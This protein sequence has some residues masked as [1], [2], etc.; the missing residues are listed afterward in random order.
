M[1]ANRADGRRYLM[2]NM[3]WL[4][5]QLGE[6]DDDYFLFDCPGQIELYTHMDVMKNIVDALQVCT[7]SGSELKR[8]VRRSSSAFLGHES[9]SRAFDCA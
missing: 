6:G 7:P 2:K 8:A 5:E 9:R 4:E 3:S 1:G